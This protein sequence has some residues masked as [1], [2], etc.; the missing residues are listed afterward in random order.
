MPL[1]LSDK[2]QPLNQWGLTLMVM[3]TIR[4]WETLD[5]VGPSLYIGVLKSELESCHPKDILC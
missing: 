4:T 1:T 5:S 2:K 3:A